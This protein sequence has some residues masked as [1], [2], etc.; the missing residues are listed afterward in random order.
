MLVGFER[1]EVSFNGEHGLT[2][3]RSFK[4]DI[5]MARSGLIP[6][7]TTEARDGMSILGMI[8]IFALVFVVVVSGEVAQ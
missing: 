5:T 8:R 7:D 6:H 3:H 2:G 1:I 4:Y